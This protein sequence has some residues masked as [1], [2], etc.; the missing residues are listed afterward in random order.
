MN[1]IVTPVLGQKGESGEGRKSPQRS[2]KSKKKGKRFC[3]SIPIWSLGASR[4]SGRGEKKRKEEKEEEEEEE[5][6]EEE[7]EEEEEAEESS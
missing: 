5:D 1:N 3:V 7:E 2:F 4:W 6:E